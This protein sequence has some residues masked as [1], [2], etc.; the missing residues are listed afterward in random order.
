M[1]K[2]KFMKYAIALLLM[3]NS[4]IA[5]PILNRNM[6]AEGTLVTIW[7]DHVDPD[8]FYYAPNAMKIS[9][10]AEGKVNF[11]LTTYR[12]GS[13][14]YLHIKKCYQ[15]AF[16]SVLLSASYETQQLT[17][18]QTGIRKIRPNARFSPVPFL[19]SQALFGETIR[20]FIDGHDCAPKAGQ[21]AD[22][23]PCTMTLNANGLYTLRPYLAEGK[24]LPMKFVYEIAGVVEGA[25]G[26]FTNERL[27]YGLAVKIGGEELIGHDDLVE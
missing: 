16:L 23:V 18:A 8:H 14:G 25:N 10:D 5:A 21:A 3:M 9:K 17:E 24:I 2:G 15:K 11:N 6:A 12:V 22:E 27:N 4:A 26:Q 20:V 19:S 1:E 13:C 7:P